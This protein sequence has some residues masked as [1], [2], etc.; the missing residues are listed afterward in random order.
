MGG[1]FS[2]LPG[3]IEGVLM[4]A[5]VRFDNGDLEIDSTGAQIYVVGAE[6][7]AQ[8]L[9]HEITLPYDSSA[10][11]GNELFEPDGRLTSIV[12]S[13][14]IGSQA[15]RTFIKTAVKR[16]QRAQQADAATD[17]SELVQSIKSLLVRNL[18]NDVTSYGFFLSVIVDDE[19]IAIARAIRMSHL[20]D[21]SR[22]LVGGYDP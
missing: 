16:L 22:P 14:E 3:L 8:D 10:D 11:R 1:G 9:L 13:Q 2:N 7:A 20:G 17:R 19:N 18:N 6:K 5:T 15:L 12:G 21:T 4:S